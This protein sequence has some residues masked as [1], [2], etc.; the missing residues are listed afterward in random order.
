MTAA[1]FVFAR[2]FSKDPAWTNHAR[3]TLAWAVVATVTFLSIPFAPDALFGVA[4]RAHIATWLSWL[5][6][7][8]IRARSLAAD[9]ARAIVV[10][11][12][13]GQDTTL[14]ATADA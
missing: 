12:P 8:M 13:A 14:G 4:Q 1:M 3:P 6:V 9:R 7:T 11:T 5:I 2:R 10:P